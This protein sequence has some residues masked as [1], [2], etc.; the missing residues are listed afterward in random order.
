MI[1]VR[2]TQ[3]IRR[4][5]V[6]QDDGENQYLDP[7]KWREFGRCS[8][9]HG[10]DGFL[11]FCRAWCWV[12]DKDTDQVI[13]FD[14]WAGQ[15]R[16]AGL[17][18]AGQWLMALKGRQTGFTTL[19][20]VFGYWRTRY[21]RHFTGMCV[22]QE[23]EYAVD[24][25]DK[26]L[27]IHERLPAWFRLNLVKDNEKKM[28]F[29]RHTCLS[30]WRVLVGKGKAGRS[31]SGDLAIF[32]EAAYIDNL[33]A[34]LT[35]VMPAL[36]G[37]EARRV[38]G[39][40]VVLSTSAGPVGDFHDLWMQTRGVHGEL[41]NDRGV[42]PTGF[43]P[44]FIHWSERYR[45]DQAWYD[46][47]AKRLTAIGGPTAIKYEHP[48]TIEEAW[49]H[50]EGRVYPLLSSETHVGTIEIPD[51]ATRYRGVDWGETVSAYVVLWIAHVPGPPGL[52]ISPECPNT[53]REMIAYRMDP[54]KPDYPLKENDHAPDVIRYVVTSM[55]LAGLVYVY[56]EIYRKDSV[57]KGWTQPKEI[58]E[59][60]T[61]SGWVRAPL[62]SRRTWMPGE[63]GE[64][65]EMTVCDRSWKKAIAEF[66]RCDIP[67]IGAKRIKGSK[68]KDAGTQFDHRDSE[69]V[70]GI[71]HVRALIVGTHDLEARIQIT[72][73]HQAVQVLR[74]V[75]RRPKGVRVSLADRRMADLA[76]QLLKR[77]ERRR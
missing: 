9:E 43:R 52:L 11:R 28:M 22:A 7:D 42:G 32:D 20:S 71:R 23:K 64:E 26:L 29:R 56:R 68:D 74:D 1:R 57:A 35:A 58:E 6:S 49:E 54:D 13:R 4:P 18:V 36:R 8:P 63:Y 39:Q 5:K 51:G 60:H 40:I 41:L 76:R 21:S 46:E 72:R 48:N 47:E 10:L 62:E 73:E 69:I 25:K 77:K 16:I 67:A 34:T 66:N 37:S 50:T 17:L 53:I 61:M 33:S 12:K 55:N 27:A 19:V 3:Y 44:E 14:P 59:I 15:V 38:P 24:F 65:I 75:Q 2:P 30:E 31:F 70:E 45:R